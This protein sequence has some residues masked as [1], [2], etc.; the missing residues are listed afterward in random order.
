MPHHEYVS[1]KAGSVGSF[2]ASMFRYDIIGSIPICAQ[3]SDISLVFGGVQNA[4]FGIGIRPQTSS[5]ALA[6]QGPM[7]PTLAG[8]G[9]LCVASKSLW[10]WWQR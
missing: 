3:V 7:I 9:E 8:H 4:S 1:L 10:T 2:G 5:F 6:V